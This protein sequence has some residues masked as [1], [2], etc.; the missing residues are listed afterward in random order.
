MMGK[1]K[2]I[3]IIKTLTTY[4]MAFP[5]CRADAGTMV[6]YARAL[7][8]LPLPAIDAA[9]QIQLKTSKWFP[10]V[11]EIRHAAESLQRTA[12]GTEIKGADE[13]WAEVLQ[14]VHDA[15][16]YHPPVFTTPEIQKVAMGLGWTALCNLPTDQIN[17]A[18]AQFRLAYNAEIERA[19]TRSENTKILIK[20]EKEKLAELCG[21]IGNG[22]KQIDGGQ[23]NE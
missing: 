10:S 2:E 11:A 19:K 9:M 15:F 20:M 23:K 14:Q 18:R 12:T 21:G 5:S 16:V 6:V 4:M 8:D 3:E 22:P 17:T 1:E 13:A 7:L